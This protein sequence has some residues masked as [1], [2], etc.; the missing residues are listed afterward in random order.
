MWFGYTR[1][2]LGRTLH[3]LPMLMDDS[4]ESFGCGVGFVFC[5]LCFVFHGLACC[6]VAFACGV[7]VV[8]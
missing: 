6:L 2:N 1:K 4:I 8:L 3:S 7:V 5:V